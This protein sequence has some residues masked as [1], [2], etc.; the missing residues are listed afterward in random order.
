MPPTDEPTTG[1][2][3]RRLDEVSRQLLDLAGQLREDRD[4]AAATFVRQDVYQAQRVADSAVVA[5]LHGDIRAVDSRT[6]ERMDK[7]ETAHAT[8]VDKRRQMWLAIGGMALAFVS[9]TAALI[10]QIVQGAG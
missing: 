8:D 7:I 6:T 1:E 4:K 5:D 2:V 3:L 10:V 9:A